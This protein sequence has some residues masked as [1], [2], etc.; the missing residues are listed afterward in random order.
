MELYLND[1]GCVGAFEAVLW[2]IEIDF[3]EATE[4]SDSVV[5]GI[6]F[7]L[8]ACDELFGFGGEP[9]IWGWCFSSLEVAV[10]SI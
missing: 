7:R 5:S 9:V 8:V 2:I 1:H 4:S 3:W 10:T 6:V